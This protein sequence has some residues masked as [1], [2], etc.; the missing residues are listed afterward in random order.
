MRYALD[1]SGSRRQYLRMV[2]NF[3]LRLL[4][5]ELKSKKPTEQNNE[6]K[7]GKPIVAICGR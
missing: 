1:V 2:I 6:K 3:Q 5:F 7:I 4:L